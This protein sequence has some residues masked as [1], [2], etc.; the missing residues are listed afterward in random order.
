MHG[1]VGQVTFGDGLAAPGAPVG[2]VP[3]WMGHASLWTPDR[4]WHGRQVRCFE[5]S[6][7]K[8]AVFGTCLSSE[9]AVLAVLARCQVDG[10]YAGL[11]ALPGSFALV[12]HCGDLI[13][14]FTDAVGLRSVYYRRHG[15]VMRFAGSSLDLADPSRDLDRAWVATRLMAR[16]PSL[17]ERKTPFA[18]VA[19]VPSGHCLTVR[20]PRFHGEEP[21]ARCRPYWSVPAGRNNLAEGAVSLRHALVEA[22]T[23]RVEPPEHISGDLSGGLDSTSLVAL[24]AKTIPNRP[25]VAVTM[26][27]VDPQTNDDCDFARRAALTFP[28]IISHQVHTEMACVDSP[29]ILALAPTMEPNMST[30]M[31]PGFKARMQA[32][33]ASDSALHLC[34]QAGDAVLMAPGAHLADLIHTRR[35]AELGRHLDRLARQCDVS[36][37]RLARDAYRLSRTRYR[38]WIAQQ[39]EALDRV[40]DRPDAQDFGIGWAPPAESCSWASPEAVRLTVSELRAHATSAVPRAEAPGQH[41]ALASIQACAR[42]ARGLAELAR[43]FGVQLEFPF[44]DRPVLDA[45]LDTDI[46]VRANPFEYKPLLRRALRGLVPE[47][48][49]ARHTKSNYTRDYCADVGRFNRRVR[50]LFS[51]STLSGLGLINDRRFLSTLE[52]LA[53][54]HMVGL[55]AFV[56]TIETEIWLRRLLASPAGSAAST[57]AGEPLTE[58]SRS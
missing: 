24:A 15:S 39:A 10:D 25:L 41:A 21:V 53:M 8:L 4:N 27:G 32:V 31:Y 52:R 18:E 49:L 56:W 46:A 44:L 54:G 12:V 17:S 51:P 34:G 40:G 5:Q 45:C 36:P 35:L 7:I 13:H 30:T 14:L 29:E 37:F 50:E 1:F 58:V 19:E 16:I 28:N 3:L 33:A 55:R 48:L 11:A 42:T 6:G 47:D 38:D 2:G 57:R 43:P 26:V 23:R 9:P 22:V 20:I